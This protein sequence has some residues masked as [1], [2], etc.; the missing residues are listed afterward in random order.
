M[1]EASVLCDEV[2]IIDR[3]RIVEQGPPGELLS[4]YF[5]PTLIRLPRS[6]FASP[7]DAPSSFAYRDGMLEAA[8]DDAEA[9]LADLR[10]RGIPLVD[11]QI[12]SPTLEDLFLKLTGHELR[13]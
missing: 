1:E 13:T 9:A 5:K 11:V 10:A 7:A 2:A 6:A 8:V 4:R 3:G 12:A